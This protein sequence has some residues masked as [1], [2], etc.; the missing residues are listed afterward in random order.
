MADKKSS[1]TSKKVKQDRQARLAQAL[2]NNLRRRKVAQTPKAS[3]TPGTRK[4]K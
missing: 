2:R 1:R 4:G 3:L